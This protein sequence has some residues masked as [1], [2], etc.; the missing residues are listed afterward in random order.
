MFQA[1]KLS[2]S[3][4]KNVMFILKV[5]LAIALPKIAKT[6]KIFLGDKEVLMFFTDVVKKTVARR[7]ATGKV[8]KNR[9]SEMLIKSNH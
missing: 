1:M 6:L 3:G 4:G 7:K 9:Q 8:R 2:G 5:L